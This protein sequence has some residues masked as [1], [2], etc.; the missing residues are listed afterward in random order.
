[1][2]KRQVLHAKPVPGQPVASGGSILAKASRKRRDHFPSAAEAYDHC[3]TRGLFARFVPEALALY[4]GE[5]MVETGEGDVT[6]KCHREIEAAVF[7]SNSSSVCADDVE[8]VS[9]RTLFVH[10]QRGNFDLAIYEAIAARMSNARAESRDLGH[11]FPLED[12]QAA[13]DYALELLRD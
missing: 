8:A 9:A 13:I 5:A 4:V 3:R 1:M 11:L 7:D 6:L 12:P 10:A 2:Y